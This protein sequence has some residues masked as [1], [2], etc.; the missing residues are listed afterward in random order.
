MN[1]KLFQTEGEENVYM[2][3]ILVS[4][5]KILPYIEDFW[6]YKADKISI[7]KAGSV[8][9]FGSAE[10]QMDFDWLMGLSIW[11]NFVITS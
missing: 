8:C 6:Y 2:N 3:R 11:P 10:F 9:S 4:L 1:R 7:K 5:E